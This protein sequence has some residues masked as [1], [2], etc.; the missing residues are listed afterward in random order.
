MKNE[1][2]SEMLRS[3]YYPKMSLF[4][5][6]IEIVL[7]VELYLDAIRKMIQTYE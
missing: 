6:W 3:I 4:P 2:W 1:E 7:T 5:F